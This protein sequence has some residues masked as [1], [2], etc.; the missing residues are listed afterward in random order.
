MPQRTCKG[1]EP[2]A[3]WKSDH[4]YI[5]DNGEVL[6]GSCMGIESTYQPC[7]YSD[8][9]LMD[10]AGM[11]EMAGVIVLCETRRYARAL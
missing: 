8:L 7:A 4:L 11:V 3:P 6:C 10:A 2:M 1:R 9:G 5:G